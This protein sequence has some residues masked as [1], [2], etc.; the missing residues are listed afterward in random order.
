MIALNG[1]H[2]LDFNLKYQHKIAHFGD[3]RSCVENPFLD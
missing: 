1:P 2:G 3:E